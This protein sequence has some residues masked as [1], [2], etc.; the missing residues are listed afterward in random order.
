MQTSRCHWHWFQ[1]NWTYHFSPRYFNGI[2]IVT[3]FKKC[4]L[5]QL[6]HN[7]K[8]ILEIVSHK[9]QYHDPVC[10][11]G[12]TEPQYS[13]I[14]WS[15]LLLK[16]HVLLIGNTHIS[17]CITSAII[18]F[19]L[20]LVCLEPISRCWNDCIVEWRHHCT[21]VCAESS[22]CMYIESAKYGACLCRHF[23]WK[24]NL[25]TFCKGLRRFLTW[26]GAEA[27][28]SEASRPSACA[29]RS[30]GSRGLAPWMGLQEG[31]APLPKKILNLVS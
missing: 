24:W 10:N 20:W 7:C 1:T 4:I 5:K 13:D 18:R 3:A 17:N 15:N 16:Y 14:C 30:R 2:K 26:G 29:R 9:N 23:S 8:P 11:S 25:H 19:I 27:T 6:C 22:M 28:A 31:S 21:S 12:F